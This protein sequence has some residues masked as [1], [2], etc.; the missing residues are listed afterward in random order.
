MASVDQPFQ[1]QDQEQNQQ[2]QT[3][4]NSSMG[5]PQQVTSG[6]GSVGGGAGSM[7]PAGGSSSNNPAPT[8]SGTYPNI[9]KYMQANQ[10]WNADQGGLGGEIT[11]NLN[12]QGQGINNQV[13]SAAN[14]FQNQ[15]NTWQQNTNQANTAFQSGLVDP[16]AYLQ[17]NSNAQQQANTAL[18]AQY[19]GQQD[20]NSANPNLNQQVQNYQTNAQQ[21]QTESGRFNL[22]Q[23]M[24]NNPTYTQG[25]KSLDQAFL[26]NSPTAQNQFQ[27]ALQNSKQ[28]ALGYQ[29]ANNAAQQS[30]QDWQN[31]ANQVQQQSRGALNASIGNEGSNIQNEYTQAQANQQQQLQA[32]QNNLAQGQLTQAQV[33]ELGLG[34][35]VGKQLYNTNLSQYATTPTLTAQ[36]TATAA[37]YARMN[38]LN[39]LAGFAPGAAN[40]ASTQL[41]A[42][43]Q[44]QPGTLYNSSNDVGFNNAAANQAI[45]NAAQS[46]QDALNTPISWGGQNAV[47]TINSYLPFVTASN[48]NTS[49]GNIIANPNTLQGETFAQLGYVM[50]NQTNVDNVNKLG[51]YVD[52]NYAKLLNAQ[53]SFYAGQNANTASPLDFYKAVL[54]GQAPE[55]Y[56]QITQGFGTNAPGVALALDALNSLM[57]TNATYTPTRTLQ[58]A[59]NQGTS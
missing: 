42:Q 39:Q 29:N 50:P 46:Y 4:A 38:A 58:I 55:T 25:Q 31:Y 57:N 22:L 2:N 48:S 24:F 6:A 49:G 52:P 51:G 9:S 16:N 5:Q 19:N 30:A 20:L 47:N 14:A 34:N 35:L 3:T 59:P 7:S 32:I 37:D 33:N 18:N 17:N 21:G 11:S 44:N 28:S 27:Q 43:Y 54:N 45:Q 41:L 13:Q 8:N 15:G 56:G 23:Q 53:A 1:P 36:N 10:N 12:Q 26:E 40:A